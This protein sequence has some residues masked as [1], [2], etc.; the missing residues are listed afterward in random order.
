MR[1]DAQRANHQQVLAAGQYQADPCR[2]DRQHVDYAKKTSRVAGR[3]VDHG[4]PHEVFQ[5]KREREKPLQC[6]EQHAQPQVQRSH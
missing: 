1:E 5:G 4:K 2:Q 6:I 3:A